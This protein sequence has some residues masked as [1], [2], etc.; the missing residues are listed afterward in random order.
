M[1]GDGMLRR[2]FRTLVW[3]VNVGPIRQLLRPRSH[4]RT[5]QGRKHRVGV[6]LRKNHQGT[7]EGCLEPF[8]DLRSIIPHV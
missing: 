6:Q 3:P 5:P 4:S 8:F 1:Q 2:L 7:Y